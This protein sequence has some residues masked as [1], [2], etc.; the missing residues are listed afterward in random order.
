MFY[1][2]KRVLVTGGTGFVGTHLVQELLK[3]G[4]FLRIP[5][6]HRPPV[7]TDLRI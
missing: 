2:A 7:V 5:V 4:A 6:H 3:Q 1:R